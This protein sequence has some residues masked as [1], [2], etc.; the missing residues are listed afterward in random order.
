MMKRTLGLLLL[1]TLLPVVGVGCSK[2]YTTPTG[3]ITNTVPA[4]SAE[5]QGP[6]PIGGRPTTPTNPNP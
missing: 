6:S 5:I 1:A 3:S 2:G 4:L